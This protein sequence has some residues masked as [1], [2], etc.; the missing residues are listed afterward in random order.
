MKIERAIPE[1]HTLLTVITKKSKAF[2]GYD[3]QQMERWNDLLTITSDYILKNETYKLLLE[4]EIIGYYS[5]LKIDPQTLKIDNLF[6]SPEFIGK[7]LG[8]KLMAD[9]FEKAKLN[10]YTSVVLDSDPNAEGFYSHL[11]FIKIDQVKTSV[12]N[13]FLPV[14]KKTL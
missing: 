2:W 11:G 4:N 14:M 8:K 3:E 9:V 6:I 12:K 7:G 1:D 10:N 5:L 13:R